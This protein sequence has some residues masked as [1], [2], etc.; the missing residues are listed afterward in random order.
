MN[1]KDVTTESNIK[2]SLSKGISELL[3]NFVETKLREKQIQFYTG[4]V[5]DNKDPEQEGR[6]RIR[7]FGKYTDE[8]EDQDLPWSTPDFNFI[9]STLGSFIVPPVDSLVKV[10]FDN[11]DFYNP[12][13][14]TKVL[15]RTKLSEFSAGLDDDYP[16]TMIFFETDGGEYFKINRKSGL[17]EYRHV[18][19][20]IVRIDSSGNLTIENNDTE[21][22]DVSINV[23]GNLDITAGGDI[24]LTSN[25]GNI[26][27]R[28]AVGEATIDGVTVNIKFVG[29]TLWSPNVLPADP[30][31]G[32]PHG[33]VAGGLTNLL[34]GEHI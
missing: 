6:C 26:E 32:V 11:D 10:Y 15:N 30:F 9:G 25:T 16:D 7:V 28:S 3:K 5:V 31:T 14:T 34:P 21:T 20:L 8:I 2:N 17:S 23:K 19:G 27:M 4:K 22:G 24:N 18:S 29:G 1:K 12:R 33:G 13:Y